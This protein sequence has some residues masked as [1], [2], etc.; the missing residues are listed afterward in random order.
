MVKLED[1]ETGTSNV[2]QVLQDL[3]MKQYQGNSEPRAHRP[4]TTFMTSTTSRQPKASNT[5]KSCETASQKAGTATYTD[6]MSQIQTSFR[7]IPT[8]ELNTSYSTRR[9]ASRTHQPHSHSEPK[10]CCMHVH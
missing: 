3:W 8:P 2:F 4:N 10:T 9:P 6:N 1:M 5:P 7:T